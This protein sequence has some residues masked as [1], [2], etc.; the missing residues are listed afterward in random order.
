MSKSKNSSSAAKNKTAMMEDEDAQME[1][2]VIAGGGDSDQSVSWEA[3][4]LQN[5]CGALTFRVVFLQAKRVKRVAVDL[6]PTT[7]DE[8]AANARYLLTQ[9]G[10]A[11][12]RSCIVR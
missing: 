7:L 8:G 11:V 5:R 10:L 3:P 12:S 1:E 6:G 9:K 2:E 4:V